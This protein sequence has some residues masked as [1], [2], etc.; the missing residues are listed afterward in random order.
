MHL[1]IIWILMLASA[2]RA[3]SITWGSF[4]DQPVVH[5]GD[6]SGFCAPGTIQQS[7]GGPR[8]V[9]TLGGWSLLPP[10]TDWITR[11]SGFE[12]WLSDSGDFILEPPDSG[13]LPVT[14]ALFDARWSADRLDVFYQGYSVGQASL[15]R[16]V[17]EPEIWTL[18]AV[19]LAMLALGHGDKKTPPPAPKPDP[20]TKIRAGLIRQ[21]TKDKWTWTPPAWMER[22]LSGH[23][24]GRGQ[25]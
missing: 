19:G 24:R 17:P 18:L 2:A 20:D 13:L 16:T 10:G 21:V 5:Q 8:Y 7:G 9:L 25:W 1:Y 14:S 6:W 12:A 3:D 23:E 22:W 4:S 11:G 15:W